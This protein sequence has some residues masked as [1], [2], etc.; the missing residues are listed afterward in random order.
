M[1]EN[2]NSRKTK[3]GKKSKKPVVTLTPIRNTVALNPLLHKGGPHQESHK[4][5]RQ[6]NKKALR[7]ANALN[8][9]VDIF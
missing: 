7:T 4:A 3:R 5:L 2:L 8:L 6:A 1:S 9:I